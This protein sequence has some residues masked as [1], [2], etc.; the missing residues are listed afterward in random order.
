LLPK[1][2]SFGSPNL[3][4]KLHTL[5][6]ISLNQKL[7]FSDFPKLGLKPRISAWVSNNQKSQISD[8]ILVSLKT[9]PKN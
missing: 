7:L 9:K 6:L 2:L 1:P 3:V 4:P 5:D 8:H